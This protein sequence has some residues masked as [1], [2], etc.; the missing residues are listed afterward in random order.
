MAAIYDSFMRKSELA[1]LRDWRRAL[2]VGLSGDVLEVGAGTGANL[3]LYP[4]AVR[5]LTVSEPDAAMRERLSAALAAERV[6]SPS[7]AVT[8]LDAP[9]ERLPLADASMDAVVCTLVLC[10]VRDPREALGELRRVLRPGGRLHY[11]EHV[12]AH[13]DPERLRWQRRVEPVWRVVAGNCHVTRD[14]GALI[15]DA[16]FDVEDERRESV[17]KALPWVR[18]SVRG[19]AVKRPR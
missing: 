4:E 10:S 14:T 15:R 18:P 17:R 8:V 9:A 3:A 19:V 2:L 1:C 7:R 12:A 11:L 16:G 5:S 6:R 13:D